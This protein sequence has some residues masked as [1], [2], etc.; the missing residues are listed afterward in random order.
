MND[1]FKYE[2]MEDEREEHPR[3]DRELSKGVET[4]RPV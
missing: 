3:G 2:N 4:R 1:E